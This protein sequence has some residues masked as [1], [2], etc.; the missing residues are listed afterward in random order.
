MCLFKETLRTGDRTVMKEITSRVRQL[1]EESSVDEGICMVYSPHTTAGITINENA[2][3]DV[4]KD[5]IKAINKIV[6]FS[7]NYDHLEGNSAAHMKTTMTGLHIMVPIHHGQLVLG[8]WQ[9]IYFCDFDGPRNRNFYVQI[10]KGI[11]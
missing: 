5:M 6:P 3:P 4:Q 1:V 9:G 2:D 8:T 7:D 11:M 10:F